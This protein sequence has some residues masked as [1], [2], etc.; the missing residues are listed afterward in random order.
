ML[1][2]G[3]LIALTVVYDTKKRAYYNEYYST[4]E[5]EIMN[6]KEPLYKE[7][8][9]KARYAMAGVIISQ[10]LGICDG[11]F[12]SYKVTNSLREEARNLSVRFTGDGVS[13]SYAF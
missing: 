9:K 11:L 3:G 2:H 5:S 13:V 10:L 6:T 12:L 7:Y 8:E 4:R 1:A